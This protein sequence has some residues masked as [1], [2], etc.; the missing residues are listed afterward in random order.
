MIEDKLNRKVK[1]LPSGEIEFTLPVIEEF[2]IENGLQVYFVKKNKLPLV[3]FLLLVNA[4]SIYDPADK[5]GLANLTAM[6]L[7]EGA[8]GLDALQLNDAVE[9]LGS[10]LSIRIDEDNIF[11]SLQTLKENLKSSMELFGK[12]ITQPHF[13]EKDFLREQ[14]K[15]LTRIIQRKDNPDD[16]ADFI[17]HY[18][19]YGK[20]NPYSN[21]YL[22]NEASAG[23][24]SVD[25]VRS[26]Y[27]KMFTPGNSALIVAG[28]TTEEELRLL[29]KNY[30]DN[31]NSGEAEPFRIS[32][33]QRRGSRIAVCHKENAMQSEIRVGQLSSKRSE[34]NFFAR[35]L[36]NTILGG[37]FSS[38]ININLREDKG[39]TYGA[40]SR[41]NYYKHQAHFYVSTSVSTENTGRAVEEILS[42]LKK[43][44]DGVT[45][46]EL[47]FAKFSIIRKFPANFETYSQIASNLTGRAIFNLPADYFNTYLDNI[48]NVTIDEVNLTAV[49]EIL[50]EEA[51]ITI[52]GDKNKIT[53][54][55]KNFPNSVIIEVDDE[56]N[57]IKV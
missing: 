29:L 13:E 51:L 18:K 50:T 49:K 40:F 22:G 23:S 4:G 35:H 33:P 14:R 19:L 36:L 2:K 9:M 25:D 10:H 31:G 28:D 8:G 24:I 15:A 20:D 57:E 54:Q 55:L 42:E 44:R 47:E 43:I 7:D 38:R 52:V 17:F 34:G 37:Q 39:Y 30:A 45:P 3:Q 12:V 1:P 27:K 46:E 53:E 32:E 48:K 56:G 16:V 6:M 21:L 5:K 41:F 11:V 26:Y